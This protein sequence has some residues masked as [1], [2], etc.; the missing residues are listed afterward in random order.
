MSLDGF[1]QTTFQHNNVT[2]PVFRHGTGPGVVILPEIPGLTPKT[3]ELGRR[4]AERGFTLVIPSLFGM[5]GKEFSL[6]YVGLQ[7]FRVCISR[8]FHVLASNHSSPVTSW[9]RALC[10]QVHAELGGPGVGVLGLCLT[11]N[12]ALSLMVDPV[13]MAPVMSEPALPFPVSPSRKRG[14]HLSQEELGKVRERVRDGVCVLGLRFTHDLMCPGQR[15]STLQR[16]LGEGFEA[17]EIDSGPGNPHSIRRLAHSVLTEEFVDEEGHPTR[18]ALSRVIEFF[19]Q[20]LI[21]PPS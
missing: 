10:R 4:I 20:R 13:V 5:P 17:I 16:E 8:E 9:L 2:Y 19:Q 7:F 1:A 6:P 3:A 11:G 21:A 14:V 15:F 12:F 18:A